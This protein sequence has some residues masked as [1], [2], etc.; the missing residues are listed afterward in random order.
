M[1]QGTNSAKNKTAVSPS[2]QCAWLPPCESQCAND[3]EAKKQGKDKFDANVP[4]V[5]PQDYV[6]SGLG[7]GKKP[8][9]YGGGT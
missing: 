7:D 2:T 4:Q 8:N 6:G 1:E 5:H 3:S 9:G